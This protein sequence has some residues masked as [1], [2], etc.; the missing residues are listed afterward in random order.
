MG[1]DIKSGC[2]SPTL[3]RTLQSLSKQKLPEE[4]II[5]SARGYQSDQKVPKTVHSSLPFKDLMLKQR[6][7]FSAVETNN[8]NLL[9]SLRLTEA[10][11][12]SKDSYG[13]TP[14]FYAA[15]NANKEIVEILTKCGAKVNERCSN[16]NTP[17][18]KAFASGQLMV[19][20]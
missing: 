16:G 8:L 10:D 18:H 19:S 20:L 6:K 15:S 14:L 12:N 1:Q 13:N 7:I 3:Q 17:M 9:L 4:R 11:V 5:N 2:S